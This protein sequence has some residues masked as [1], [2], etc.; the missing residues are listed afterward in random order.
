VPHGAV[1]APAPIRTEPLRGASTDGGDHRPA[2]RAAAALPD[3]AEDVD[4][5]SVAT[6]RFGLAYER[7]V[8]DRFA[9][10][11]PALPDGDAGPAGE[12]GPAE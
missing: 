7:A 1:V 5:Y 10:L 6:L 9:T 12:P 4:P 2:P 3:E 11:P 8:L